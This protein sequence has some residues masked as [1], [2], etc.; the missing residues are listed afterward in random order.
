MPHRFALSLVVLL[1]LAHP[2]IT[3]GQAVSLRASDNCFN[4]GPH[5]LSQKI[6]VSNNEIQASHWVW[7]FV[8]TD[9]EADTII[10][11][12]ENAEL[13]LL[14]ADVSGLI[15]GATYDVRIRPQ[16][17]GQ[18]ESPFGETQCLQVTS[19]LLAPED[20]PLRVEEQD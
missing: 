18:A 12:S 9:I 20:G 11:T 13:H 8:R 3:R 7:E 6:S 15:G 5:F 2:F 19:P 14:L 10:H 4:Y 16:I 1:F 17:T